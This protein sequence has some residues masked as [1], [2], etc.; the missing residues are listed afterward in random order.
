MYN[1]KDII[2][3]NRE[4]GESGEVRD[5]SS[6]KFALSIVK[7]NKSWIYELSYIIRSLIVDHPFIDGNKRTAYVLCSIYFSDHNRKL[8]KQKL[9][10]TIYLIAKKN[11]SDINKI[12]RK[13]LKC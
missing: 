11:I 1:F 8:N 6:L 2:R 12:A 9:V 3:I 4:V 10:E 5:E 13:I 7:N